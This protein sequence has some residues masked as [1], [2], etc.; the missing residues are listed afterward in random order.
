M[1]RHDD[2][3]DDRSESDRRILGDFG[4][5]APSGEPSSKLFA[6][7]RSAQQIPLESEMLPDWSEAREKF[8]CAFRVAKATHATLALT[9]RLVDSLCA[10]V[11][12]GCRF[13]EYVLHIRKIR[14][15]GFCRRIAAQLIGDDLARRRAQTQYTLEEAF[16]SGWVAPFLQQDVEFGAMLVDR[17]PQQVRLATKRDERL[18]Q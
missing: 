3:C 2:R 17:T 6:I 10:V 7:K 13:Y 18:C 1:R 8:L 9:R 14:D 16:G 4:E 12:P 11:Q 5:F 15:P